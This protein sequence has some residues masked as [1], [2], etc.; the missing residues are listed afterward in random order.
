M[1]NNTCARTAIWIATVV[2][3]ASLVQASEPQAVA[4][5]TEF[6]S[7]AGKFSVLLPGDPMYPAFPR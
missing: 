7:A 4:E 3:L 5:L 1:T 2:A 6:T